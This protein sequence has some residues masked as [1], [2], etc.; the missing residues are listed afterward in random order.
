[1]G[2]SAAAARATHT[3]AVLSDAFA[4]EMR[5][6]AGRAQARAATAARPTAVPKRVTH[7]PA[8]EEAEKGG[9]DVGMA[10]SRAM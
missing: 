8:S 7:E 5:I 4:L 9:M 3:R 1:M 6:A 10:G 2:P